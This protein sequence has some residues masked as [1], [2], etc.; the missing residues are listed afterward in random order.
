M[1]A[2]RVMMLPNHPVLLVL[3]PGTDEK[4]TKI[5]EHLTHQGMGVMRQDERYVID[6]QLRFPD[7]KQLSEDEVAALPENVRWYKCGY[8]LVRTNT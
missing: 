6:R 7:S 3:Q 1:F 8:G 4:R 2:H 5:V